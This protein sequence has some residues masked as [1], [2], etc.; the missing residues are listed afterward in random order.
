M[1]KKPEEEKKEGQLAIPPVR[2]PPTWRWIL[3][4]IVIFVCGVAVGAGGTVIIGRNALR[5]R[6]F[7]VARNPERAP[8]L[9]AGRIRRELR[10]SPEQTEQVET[11]VAQRLQAIREL[12]EQNRPLIAE[13]LNRLKEEVGKVLNENQEREWRRRFEEIS[14]LLFPPHPPGPRGPHGPPG[15]P[16]GRR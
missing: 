6:M 11:I 13:Q 1:R 7:N 5:T 15:P 9:I 12:R 10:L 14:P 8:H 2:T 4:G 3:L 16:P